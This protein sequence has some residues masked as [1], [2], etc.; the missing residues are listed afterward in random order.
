MEFG[1]EL[2]CLLVEDAEVLFDELDRVFGEERKVP[3]GPVDTYVEKNGVTMDVSGITAL[4]HNPHER[5]NNTNIFNSINQEK[6]LKEKIG[7]DSKTKSVKPFSLEDMIETSK[8]KRMG[9]LQDQKET[10]SAV[11]AKSIA[12]Y[13]KDTSKTKQEDPNGMVTPVITDSDT[14]RDDDEE[15]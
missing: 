5:Q 12:T 11:Y 14:G 1:N 3:D 9:E 10:L 6:N 4:Q 7:G 15:H 2:E 8:D 13:K